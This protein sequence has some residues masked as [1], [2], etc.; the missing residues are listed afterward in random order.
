[1]KTNNH[2]SSSFLL[3]LPTKKKSAFLNFTLET[4]NLRLKYITV[5]INHNCQIFSNSSEGKLMTKKV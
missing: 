2:F 1:M 4:A 5:A 3:W